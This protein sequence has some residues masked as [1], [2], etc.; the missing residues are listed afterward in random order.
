[1]LTAGRQISGDLWLCMH[2][3]NAKRGGGVKFFAYCRNVWKR[4]SV[5]VEPFQKW[6]NM[7]WQAFPIR[8]KLSILFSGLIL[9]MST[10]FY[11][12]AVFQ[13]TREIKLSAINKGQAIAE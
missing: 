8:A 6:L 13:T 3:Q 1:M 5:F 9:A 12:F 2:S 7:V 11:L 10:F 4:F